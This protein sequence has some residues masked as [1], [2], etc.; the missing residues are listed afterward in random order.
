MVIVTHFLDRD[1]QL[2]ASISPRRFFCLQCHVVQTDVKV[3]VENRSSTSTRWSRPPGGG[4][5][6]G[7]SSGK[8]CVGWSHT[9]TRRA[10]IAEPAGSC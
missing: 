1:G 2:L 5:S 10:A 8:R 4:N 6:G 7:G 9:L 3:P